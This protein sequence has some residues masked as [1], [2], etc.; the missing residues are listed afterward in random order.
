[1]ST[2]PNFSLHMTVAPAPFFKCFPNIGYSMEDTASHIPAMLERRLTDLGDKYLILFT[3]FKEIVSVTTAIKEKYDPLKNQLT[4]GEEYWGLLLFLN[5]FLLE[6][7][8]VLDIL[9]VTLRLIH[10]KKLPNS[11]NSIDAEGKHAEIFANDPLFY[12]CLIEAKRAEWTGPLLSQSRENSS[13]R[14][15]IAH[16]TVARELYPEANPNFTMHRTRHIWP[17]RQVTWFIASLID[18]VLAP[19]QLRFAPWSA[20]RFRACAWSTNPAMFAHPR[21]LLCN[22]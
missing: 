11:F 9:A 21:G 14:D 1:M 8:S 2:K 13:L 17:V 5:H 10:Q 6:A 3:A 22:P 7:R 19:H 12:N 18:S 16:N 4:V 20:C 15:R